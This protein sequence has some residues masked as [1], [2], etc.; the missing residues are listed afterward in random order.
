MSIR[1]TSNDSLHRDL[2]ADRAVFGRGDSRAGSFQE[3]LDQF[4]VR[5]AVF[6]QQHVDR[7]RT[8]FATSGRLALRPGAAVCG[9]RRRDERDAGDVARVDPQRKRA[10]LAD[11]ADGRQVAAQAAG[12]FPRDRQTQPRAAE[13]PRDRAVGLHERIE[14]AFELLLHDAD[15]RVDHVEFDLRP[16]LVLDESSDDFDRSLGR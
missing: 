15:A 3:Q 4:A 1:I 16:P 11:L 2:A 6:D 7:R 13:P 12:D 9:G 10:A 8:T 14:N 5:V